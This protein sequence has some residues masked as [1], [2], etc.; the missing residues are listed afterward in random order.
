MSRKYSFNNAG[1][2]TLVFSLKSQENPDEYY[3]DTNAFF[4]YFTV[5]K[6]K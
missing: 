6:Q 4:L 2:T 1:A 5:V 3:I